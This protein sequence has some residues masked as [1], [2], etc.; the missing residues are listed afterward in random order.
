MKRSFTLVM[1]FER[2]ALF[3]FFFPFPVIR[4][5]DPTLVTVHYIDW[6]ILNWLVDWFSILHALFNCERPVRTESKSSTS[7]VHVWFTVHVTRH[8][9]WK[10]I[11]RGG[12]EGNESRSQTLERQHSW[13]WAKHA[14]LYSDLL[15][16]YRENLWYLGILSKG[17]GGELM[18]CT[19]G[20]TPRGL[21][22]WTSFV[23]SR[24]SWLFVM[25][26]IVEESPVVYRQTGLWYLHRFGTYPKPM[27]S[28]F[29]K[30]H[31]FAVITAPRLLLLLFK[32]K[33]YLSPP[34][35]LL[36]MGCYGLCL[37]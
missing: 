29:I 9:S 6:L 19:R 8:F 36:V 21:V 31:A 34:D 18:F 15:H 33:N 32:K 27:H 37:T 10:R 23:K 25:L 24:R 11:W 7:Q 2:C 3:F 35:H 16:A 5:S 20:T 12:G 1:F 28:Y 13:Q 14:K 4:S 30:P 22:M 17:G 26:G